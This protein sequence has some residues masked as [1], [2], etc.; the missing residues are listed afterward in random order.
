MGR[1]RYVA[2][3]VRAAGWWVRLHRD[4]G[5]MSQSAI[6][7]SIPTRRNSTGRVQR[8]CR[9][10]PTHLPRPDCCP[11]VDVRGQAGH[12]NRSRPHHGTGRTNHGQ[13]LRCGSLGRSTCHIGCHHCTRRHGGESG[14]DH[15]LWDRRLWDLRRLASVEQCWRRHRRGVSGRRRTSQYSVCGRYDLD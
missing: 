2:W 6:R 9:R 14:T 3:A 5:A 8:Q 1:R 7:R 11:N 4:P 15:R 13:N 10:H 12:G